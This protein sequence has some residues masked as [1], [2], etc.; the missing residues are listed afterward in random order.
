MNKLTLAALISLVFFPLTAMAQPDTYIGDTAIYGGTTASLKPN[1]LIVFDTSGSMGNQVNVQ[2][3][4]PDSDGDG[5]ADN[6]D[7]CVNTPNPS[8]TDT[9]G[10]GLGDACDNN[11]TYPDTDGDGITDNIDNC[12][13]VPNAD[14]ADSNGDGVG[15]ACTLTT[16]SYNP[17]SDYTAITGTKYC[18]KKE[19]GS[20]DK[21]CK[22]NTVYECEQKNWNNGTCSDW[23][24]KISN[25]TNVYCSGPR[26]K[27][28]NNGHW[29][30]TRKLRTSSCQK[31]DKT[32]QYA[33]GNWIVWYNQSGGNAD[34]DTGM[35]MEQY[36][37]IP[38]ADTT[39]DTSAAGQVCT[40]IRETKN[41]I[42]RNVV[43]DLIRSTDGVNFGLIGF[44]YSQGGSFRTQNVG[45]KNYT[46]YVKDMTATHTVSGSVTITNEDALIDVVRTLPANSWTPLGETLFES[47]RYFQGGY[48]A[49]N[50]NFKYTSPITASCQENYIIIIT[51]GMATM[52]NDP[53]LRSIC[54]AGDCDGDRK[55][56]SG[57][58]WYGSTDYLDDVAKYLHDTDLSPETGTSGFPGTQNALTFTIG[59]GLGGADA[60][61]V[62]LLKDTAANGGGKAYLASNY[63]TLTG[64]LTSIIGQI[65]EVNSAFVAPVV[66]TSP[67]NKTYSGRR[68]Y[69]GF[70]KPIV[71]NDWQGNLK[72]FGINHDG[73]VVDKNGVV[74]TDANGRFLPT[75]TSF[76]S[77][78]PDGGNVNEGGIGDVLQARDLAANPR[79]I[80]TYLGTSKVLTQP[81]NLFSKSNTSLTPAVLAVSTAADRDLIIDYM[82]GYDSYDQDL[83]GITAEKRAWIMG[84]ILH[85][86][87]LI[88]P[89]NN[90]TIN[91]ESDPNLNKTVIFYGGNDGMLHAYRDA[92][93]VELWAFVPPP[94]LSRLKY[95]G[96]STHQYFVDGSP[97][98]YVYDADHDGNIGPGPETAATDTDPAGVTDN[99]QKD[100]VILL[101]GMRRGDGIDTLDPTANRGYYFALDVTNP[102]AP[103]F[104]WDLSG[105]TTGFSELG[106]TWSDP[107]IGT[108]R[109]GSS[110][111]V[112]AFIGAGYDN[113]EDLRFGNTQHFPDGTSPTSQTTLPTADGGSATSTGTSDQVNPRGRGIYL[114][115]LATLN[116]TGP[117]I[118]TAPTKLWEY[119]Y[120][121]ARAATDPQNNPTYSFAS[122]LKPIDSNFDGY[123]DLV[124]AGDTGGN[125][126]RFDISSKVSAGN[127]DGKKIFS[128]NPSDATISGETPATQG[129]K[130]F[131]PPSVV[132]ESNYI[133]IY[134]GT[135]DRAHP[136]NQA[137]TDRLYA[138]YDYHYKPNRPSNLAPMTEANLVNLTQDF[139]QAS[140]PQPNPQDLST[141]T[142]TD[143]STGCTLQRLFNPQY[144]GWFVKLDQ[145]SGE[146]ILAPALVYNKV[147][148][149]T[150]FTPNVMTSDPCLSGNL[151]IGKVYAVDYKTGEA[152][153]NFDLNNDNQYASNTNIR[154]TTK[155]TGVILRRSDRVLTLG[156][157]IPSGAVITVHEDRSAG[158]LIGCGGG[159][160]TSETKS[161]GS[162]QPLYW[163]RE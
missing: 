120:S 75:S 45:G 122:A 92:D 6:K 153:F 29:T 101:V 128:A 149:F 21:T 88:Q 154:A 162:Y 40:T 8:Q 57:G 64:A 112:V 79:K 147:A 11:T 30:G 63:Q 2:V 23:K 93:G 51:D 37:Q 36:A 62:Q 145:T 157:G 127:W 139:L 138:V 13:T 34:L 87:P 27:L 66:P 17:N 26:N 54:S 9:D 5:I 81:V 52:D 72:K 35:S 85:S 160:C 70:F 133:G 1:V 71:G 104:L 110:N 74:A 102:T 68:V 15:D 83:D 105:T 59:F 24:E 55:E 96:G 137:V 18:G 67:E 76:W 107:V 4:E 7:N 58:G 124:Y 28:I 126:W 146:K 48:S 19:N 53:V 32:Y 125:I 77:V 113:N 65:L 103:Q 10:D 135:G 142:P 148:Y 56:Q 119:V 91:N 141:C 33:T 90:Y 130:I 14:Q 86:K 47:L 150:S 108:V 136:L 3:C 61:A 151:G 80:Y 143:T 60:Q 46:T 25:V 100:K 140:S 95:L 155:K 38:T 131:Y 115:E 123:V 39:A 106:E 109:L 114:L 50:G 16:G 78:N 20:Y 116:T 134:F 161:G 129:R 159:L 156:A 158:A 99:G 117:S 121:S 82:Q 89:Y 118:N 31:E 12:P 73:D 44:N 84:D 43:E 49:F 163:L 69:L 94:A 132:Q 144:P 152:V 98:V 41:Q 22:K 111:K 42:A 97:A